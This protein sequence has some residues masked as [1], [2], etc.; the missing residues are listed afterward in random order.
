MRRGF[1]LVFILSL[2]SLQ[3]IAMAVTFTASSSPTGGNVGNSSQIINFSVANT[4]SVN[5][6]QLN[7]TSPSGFTYVAHGTSTSLYTS[8]SSAP[9]WTNTSSVGIV[10]NGTTQY[11]WVY[12]NT[13]TSTGSYGFNIS[14]MDASNS[15]SS[16]NVTFTLFDTLYPTYSS[17]TTSLSSNS[18]YAPNQSYWFNVTWVDNGDISKVLLEHNFTTGSIHNETMN[19]SSSVY[20]ANFSDLSAGTYVWRVYANDTNNTFNST[21]QTTY[22]VAQA[23]NRISVYLN[24]LLNGNTT[25]VNNTVVNATVDTTCKQS[26]CKIDLSLDGSVIADDASIPYS[27]N[28]T[29]SSLGL[30]N[31]SITTSGNTNYTSNSSIYSVATVPSYTTSTANLPLTFSNGSTS[32]NLTFDSIPGIQSAMIEGDWSG[33]NTN[34]TMSNY[35][36]TQFYYTTYL[37]AGTFAWRM[38]G[39]FTNN[40][41]FN[42]TV[43]SS[44][45][46][47]K[48]TPS[49]TLNISP[50]WTLDSPVGTNVTC[51]V[52]VSGLT[53]NL[54]RNGTL[55]SGSDV[56]KFSA[57]SIYEYMCN[58]TV[59]VNYTA[60][61]VKNTLL[62]RKG[63]NAT[64]EFIN[65]PTTIEVAQDTTYTATIKVKNTGNLAQ[66][67][68]L[69]ILDIDSGWYSIQPSV[70]H[71]LIGVTESFDVTFNISSS[72][73]TKEY[74]GTFKVNSSNATT[75]QNFK[76]KVLP[77][78]RTKME[79]DDTLALINLQVLKLEDAITK[80]KALGIN[81]TDV[82]EKLNGIK[83]TIKQSQDLINSGDYFSAYQNFESI[84]SSLT[85]AEELLKS[86]KP[87]EG[88]VISFRTVIIIVIAVVVVFGIAILAYL[89]WPEKEGFKHD[90]SE[91]VF[92]GKEK[93]KTFLEKIKEKLE[94]LLSMLRVKKEGNTEVNKG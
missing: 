2:I 47:N 49:L 67:V 92:K 66:S 89:F 5:I 80:S 1:A 72:V 53:A 22:L 11:F 61:T 36:T 91:Y 94:K 7:I 29:I 42:L 13:P 39:N 14:T 8:S 52:G 64:Y 37:P 44:F 68:S 3:A 82:E 4:G 73:D 46:V 9:T 6:T 25:S 30:H 84:K 10:G 69:E 83:T 21:N 78:N 74:S 19:N 18:S 75:T 16:N 63:P 57:G 87:P 27:R 55:I 86:A 59:N 15:F 79:I 56:Q 65:P 85:E 76:L 34:Y 90:T 17:N 40:H 35:S 43:Q 41:K 81:T 77:S 20:Y 38:Y 50:Q 71:I 62:I 26:A 48:A 31:Y 33:T 23:T 88:F 51:T 58:N 93:A 70:R 28:D 12:V 45:T 60:G 32:F 54:Y 24:G